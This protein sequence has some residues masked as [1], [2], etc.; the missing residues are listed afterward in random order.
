MNKKNYILGIALIIA[1]IIILYIFL[2]IPK[3]SSVNLNFSYEPTNQAFFCEY[4]S[5]N[6]REVNWKENN[7]LQVKVRDNINCGNKVV[8]GSYNLEGNKIILYYQVTG[9]GLANCVSC[10]NMTYEITGLEKKE[11]IFEL[12]PK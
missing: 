6:I 8:G 7:I 10:T 1:V 4:G 2:A 5:S 11:Y 3:K 9:A 12:K